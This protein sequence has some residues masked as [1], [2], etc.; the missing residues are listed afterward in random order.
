MQPNEILPTPE[1]KD[2]AHNV[3]ANDSSNE[4]EATKRTEAKVSSPQGSAAISGV[5]VDDAQ[6]AV[7]SVQGS[8]GQVNLGST[9][10]SSVQIDVPD[11]AEDLDLIEKEWVVKAKRI[12]DQT[13]GDPYSQNK[14]LSSMKSEYIKKRYNREIQ[15]G[16]K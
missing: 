3:E 5:A 11:T 15:Q 6:G 1:M 7:Q 14:Q 13:V 16:E 8:S 2:N 10:G 9:A 12:V 4:A